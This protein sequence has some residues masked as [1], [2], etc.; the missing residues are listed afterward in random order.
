MDF[1]YT[2]RSFRKGDE[3]RVRKFVLSQNLG[4][5]RYDEWGH[6]A[7]C[8]LVGGEK[9]AVLAYSDGFLVGDA[10]FQEHRQLNGFVEIKNLRIH[11]A[12]RMREFGRFMTKQVERYAS[13]SGYNALICDVRE[14]KPEIAR[15]L[16]GIGFIPVAT[17]NL[18]DDGKRDVTLVKFFGK[19]G[20]EQQGLIKK[21][22]DTIQSV[23]F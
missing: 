17:L 4:Y 10:I 3:N 7:V 23:A 2:F 1:N 14:N 8:Q 9:Q 19:F 22:E 12:L 13:S 15:F 16:M 6:R 11:P 20:E 5:P 18:Y 21:V